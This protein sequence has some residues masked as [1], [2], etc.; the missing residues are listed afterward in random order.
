MKL[1]KIFGSAALTAL[2]V[3]ALV[4]CNKTDD[5]TQSSATNNN[6]TQTTQGGSTS[7][8]GTITLLTTAGD[9]LKAVLEQAE[10]VFEEAN[11]GWDVQITNG[12]GYDTLNTKVTSDLTAGNQ[13]TLAFCY[14][15]HVAGYLKTKKVIDF[16]KFIENDDDWKTNYLP[17]MIQS[18]YDEGTVFGDSSKRYTM[19]LAKSTDGVYI[20]ETVVG[21]ILTEL[22]IDV[23]SKTSW[24]WDNLWKVC[25]KLK[26]I[27]PNSTPLGYDSESNWVITYLEE[28]GAK[29]NT[30]YYTDGTK[31]SSDKLL[32]NNQTT[33][34][35]FRDVYNQYQNGYVTTKNVYGS[36]TSGLFSIYDKTLDTTTE[37]KNSYAGSFISIGST[38]GASYQLPTNGDAQFTTIVAPE[39]SLSDGTRKQISQGPSL[40]MFDQGSEEV[41]QAAWKFVKVLLSDSVQQAYA[42]ASAGY[43]PVRSDSLQNVIE[44]LDTDTAK[45]KINSDCLKLL[46][47]VSDDLYTSDCFNG[48]ATVRTQVG[49][50]LVTLLKNTSSL[51]LDKKITAALNAAYEECEYNI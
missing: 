25:A 41:Q 42:V 27:Y 32:F 48:S 23:N 26:E 45:G 38:G 22:G 12:Y 4:S 14:G 43:S 3:L 40:V 24:T 34:D 37:Y 44:S 6:S 11:P 21:P 5:A 20:N 51:S 15:D 9:T 18:Y 10:K 49:N 39:P 33:K 30:K 13:P 8:S 17:H 7:T 19:P 50:A 29:N 1:N 2:G 28:M 36:Y 31:K 35:F 47:D 46:R 16:N